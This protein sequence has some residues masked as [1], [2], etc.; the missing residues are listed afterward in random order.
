MRLSSHYGFRTAQSLIAIER[1]G[2]ATI[3]VL[4]RPHVFRA[5]T[6]TIIA[7]NRIVDN[8]DE[9][10]SDRVAN[11]SLQHRSEP[12]PYACVRRT[13]APWE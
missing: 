8:S 3:A 10:S 11:D 4:P 5:A 1:Y 13:I 9:K 6:S 12:N 7:T 2:R